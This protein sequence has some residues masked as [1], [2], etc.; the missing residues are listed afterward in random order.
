M[1]ALFVIFRLVILY[2]HYLC[3]C[4]ACYSRVCGDSD[5]SVVTYLFG[6]L[7][8]FLTCT[9]IAPDNAVSDYLVILVQHY[10][11]VHLSR[12]TYAL[13]LVCGNS[14]LCNYVTDTVN[15]GVPPVRRILLGI[16]VAGSVKR[17][18]R[19]CNRCAVL[20]EKHCFCTGRTYIDTEYVCHIFSPYFKKTSWNFTV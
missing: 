9:L 7:D 12:K 17:I 18:K 16:A 13:Y 20:A 3:G 4:K 19:R 15:A 1:A 2:P 8:N 14:A 10:K 6:Y 11:S 5:K